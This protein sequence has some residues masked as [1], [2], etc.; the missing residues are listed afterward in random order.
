MALRKDSALLGAIAVYR[1]EVR[2]FS[3]K[4]IALLRSFAAQAVIATENAR[5]L[6]E[7]R[8]ALEQQTATADPRPRRTVAEQEG[9]PLRKVPSSA[10]AR[11]RAAGR[12]AEP[13]GRS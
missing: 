5:L 11:I 1:Q 12:G 2:P 4:Q 3:E 7:T 9:T 8:E 6:T 13:P 10:G